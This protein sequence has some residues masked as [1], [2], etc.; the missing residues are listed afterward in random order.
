MMVQTEEVAERAA[1]DQVKECNDETEPYRVLTSGL[2]RT[3]HGTIYQLKILMLVVM[4]AKI[5]KYE[6]FYLATEMDMA[7][8]FDDVVFKFQPTANGDWSWRFMQVKHKNDAVKN[9]ITFAALTSS[10][11]NDFS[12]QKYFLSFCKI[13]SNEFFKG[14]LQDFLIITNIGFDEG[15]ETKN[16]F[17]STDDLNKDKILHFEEATKYKFTDRAKV[18]L[19]EQ[20]K[21][22]LLNRAY[23][24]KHV[25]HLMAIQDTLKK[26]KDLPSKQAIDAANKGIKTLKI[27]STSTSPRKGE[28][29]REI[30][31]IIALLKAYTD[32][33]ELEK[34]KSELNKTNGKGQPNYDKK[35]IIAAIKNVTDEADCVLS[36]V[37]NKKER[38]EKELETYNDSNSTEYEKLNNEK[39]TLR[40]YEKDFRTV[41]D[42]ISS[43]NDAEEIKAIMVGPSAKMIL[44]KCLKEKMNFDELK[45]KLINKVEEVIEEI[46]IVH[47]AMNTDT[48][49]SC[50]DDFTGKFYIVTNFPNEDQLGHLIDKELR[51]NFAMFKGE[52][53]YDSLQ[54]EMLDFF[55]N[56]Q[57]KKSK[58]YSCK[59][60][61]Q[62]FN[63]IN[64]HEE[65]V[66]NLHLKNMSLG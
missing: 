20:F 5:E 2:K 25:V 1:N 63:C 8:K 53:M 28:T 46:S 26:L 35:L 3:L 59:E 48:F 19:R 38:L 66:L 62:F 51:K 58:F 37:R 9:K 50:F 29:M 31:K 57:D 49:E 11:D 16:L 24:S 32:C 61:T 6:T 22:N 44:D 23:E 4:R 65:N 33:D 13:N 40:K 7:D 12:L 47:V 10:N 34:K 56:Y 64:N 52:L 14:E 42:G 60:A 27:E 30:R 17:L 54:R 39:D 18:E 45:D 21:L 36:N 15:E 55:K 41:M 43:S